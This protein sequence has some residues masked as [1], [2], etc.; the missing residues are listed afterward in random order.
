[1]RKFATLASLLV[2]AAL[3][4][5]AAAAL[6]LD[7]KTFQG[8]VKDKGKAHGDKD[9]FIFSDGKFRSTACDA[10]G[11]DSGTYKATQ[12]GDAWAFEAQTHSK[13]WGTMTWKGTIKGDSIEGTAVR[14]K[15]GKAKD[16]QVF[17]GTLKQ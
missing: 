17:S 15:D 16:E 3:F 14:S 12:Q 8:E 2:A 9:T 4:G 10:Y 1:M 11:Y 7:G 6:P 13:K 5:T